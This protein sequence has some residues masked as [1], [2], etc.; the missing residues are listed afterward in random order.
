[1]YRSH[2]D[3]GGKIKEAHTVT[4]V[5]LDISALNTSSTSPGQ[6]WAQGVGQISGVIICYDATRVVT[7]EGLNP[8]MSQLGRFAA[9][10]KFKS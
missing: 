7:L 5:E 9:L 2:V 8:A 4:Y 6:T 3:P 10:Q 1:M